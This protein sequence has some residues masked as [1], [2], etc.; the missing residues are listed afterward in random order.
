MELNVQQRDG[1][2]VVKVLIPR[3]DASMAA[4]FKNQLIEV[5]KDGVTKLVLDLSAVGFIDSSGLGALVSVLKA[6]NGKGSIAVAG[7]NATVTG[8]F[9][10]TSMDR[11]FSIYPNVDAVFA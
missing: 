9:K 7:A 2:T 4:N 1:A 8:L 10:L 11:V 5:I 3:L 6:M